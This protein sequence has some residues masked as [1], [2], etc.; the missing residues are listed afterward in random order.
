MLIKAK[1]IEARLSWRALLHVLYEPAQH[2]E[3][4]NSLETGK[5]DA[6]FEASTDRQKIQR[7]IW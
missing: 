7:I 2:S 6:V 5:E 1:A 3:Y 4:A